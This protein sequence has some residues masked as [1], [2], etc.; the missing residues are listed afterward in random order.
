MIIAAIV[1]LIVY[2]N[3]QN[4][5]PRY[6]TERV[7]EQDLVQTVSVTGTVEAAEKVD[8]NFKASGRLS[9]LSVKVGD[10]VKAG[11]RL[12]T[13]Q[14]GDAQAAVLS[15]QAQLEQAQAAVDKLNAG[16]SVEDVS[17][18]E[19]AVAAAE[20][21][22]ANAE[23]SLD[24]TK[25]TQDQAV[26]NAWL[27]LVG[28]T[29]EATPKAT[30][31]STVTITIGGTYTG[32]ET[33]SYTI[34]LDNP[35][36]LTYSI[37]GL[38]SR[39]GNEGSRLTTTA[40]GSYGLTIQFSSTGT[41]MAGDEWIAEIPNTSSSS[42]TTYKAA[43]DAALTT[44]NQ[45]VDAAEAT[46]LAAEQALIEAEAKL[47]LK[48]APA[49]SF[50][51]ASATAAVTAAKAALLKAQSDLADR[52][53]V[54]PADGTITKINNQAGETTSLA[55]PVLVLL[56]KGNY[57][58]TMQVPEADVAK[59]DTGQV[60]DITLDAFGSGQHFSGHIAF[61]DPAS[62]VL[63]DV[64]YYEVTVLFDNTD[65]GIKPGMTANI[66]VTTAS[67]SGVLV[68]PL[69][70]VKYDSDFKPFV[71]VMQKNTLATRM[72]ELGLKGDDGLVEVTNGLTAGE[73][74]VTSKT[75][76]K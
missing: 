4:T 35:V 30:N 18:S 47:A 57:E 23:K 39:Y 76:G 55:T 41:F 21:T 29:P 53:I 58:I 38:E 36:N 66:D 8:L 20:V 10:E 16:A 71:E 59:L 17:V 45:Q 31:V 64:V 75:N 12:A 2:Q 74:V 52:S 19:A 50:D 48:Q 69:R 37:F 70:A 60:A 27:Q 33:G 40:L 44:R 49:R 62:T 25:A 43:Y 13:L 42:Y 11:Q 56:S 1:T 67:R 54:A 68:I 9:T 24:N 51:L 22:L 7:V 34:R 46:V 14:S 61:V 28:L 73:L 65:D 5:K 63:S 26:A 6:T 32:K 3:K 72:V 15:A